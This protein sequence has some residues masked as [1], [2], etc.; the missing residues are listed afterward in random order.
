MNTT[1]K[2]TVQIIKDA[3]QLTEAI[4][5]RYRTYKKT[6]PKLLENSTRLYESDVFDSRSIHLGLYCEAAF[7]KSLAGYCRLIIPEYFK[8]SYQQYLIKNH[9]LY[10]AKNS[11]IENERL[12]L[13]QYTP[14]NHSRVIKS[15]CRELEEKEQAYSETSRFI[16]DDEHRSLS[17]SAFFAHSMFA[18]ATSLKMEFNFFSCDEHHAAFYKKNGLTMFPELE[19]YHNHIFQRND[20]IFGT[21]LNA[22]NANQTIINPLK[23][24]MEAENRI[25]FRRAA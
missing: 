24:Q 17:L 12:A 8:D 18:I 9:H 25:T 3:G 6:Y 23:V 14:N 10:P 16:I 1:L 7:G 5:L 4:S 13:F 20:C 11:E 15:F 19:P 21:D 22:T 2:Y